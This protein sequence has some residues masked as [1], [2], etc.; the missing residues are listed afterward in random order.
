MKAKRNVVIADKKTNPRFNLGL[1]GELVEPEKS[2]PEAQHCAERHKQWPYRPAF[3][4]AV[5]KKRGFC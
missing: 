5:S 2:L 3:L 4:R 1:M